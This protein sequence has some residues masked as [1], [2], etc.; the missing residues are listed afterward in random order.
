MAKLTYLDIAKLDAGADSALV[1]EAIVNA[2]E[3][4]TVPAKG[5]VGTTAQLTV[6]T[7]LGTVGFRK[8]NAGVLPVSSTFESRVFQT[9]NLDAPI[10]IDRK[11]VSGA[12]DPARVLDAEAVGVMEA[13]FQKAGSQF[14]Y[15][16]GSD[17][18]FPGLIAQYAADTAHTVDV[19]GT[20][21]KSSVWML[22]LGEATC[23]FLL[24]N[25]QTIKMGE[26]KEATETD[27]DGTKKPVM[28]NWMLSSLGLQL[29]NKNSAVRIKN[30]GTA[31]GKTLTDAHLY[32]AFAKFTTN[33]RKPNAIFMSPRSLE[34]LRAS[35]TA[36]TVTG[37]AAPLPTMWNGIPIIS[38]SSISDDEAV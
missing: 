4:S 27:A 30:I 9:M 36:T 6:R 29:G 38:T 8:F 32:S 33:K 14:Y 15:G 34:Q 13:A 5:I 16:T 18:G 17:D 20:S 24:G 21:A 3:F 35:R 25:D 12:K 1:E 11:L 22:E 2:P 7:G 37:E 23:A 26:W 19:T 28:E 10:T 31:A